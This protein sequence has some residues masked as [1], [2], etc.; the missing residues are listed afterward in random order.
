MESFWLVTVRRDNLLKGDIRKTGFIEHMYR[1][2]EIKLGLKL[3][4][5][6]L[7]IEVWIATDANT[8]WKKF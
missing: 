8:Y 5:S 3:D 7:S 2:M 6:S 4:I 1:F